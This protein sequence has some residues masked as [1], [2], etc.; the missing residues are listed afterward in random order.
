MKT[1]QS[2]IIDHVVLFGIL[3]EEDLYTIPALLP[4]REKG[5]EAYRKIV[6]GALDAHCRRCMSVT[7]IMQPIQDAFGE[8]LAGADSDS[9]DAFIAYVSRKRGY[10]PETIVLFY[11]GRDARANKL[12]L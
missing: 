3:H 8:A 2:L 11:V 9:L 7:K 10:R 1:G 6:L 12:V 4:L 5:K